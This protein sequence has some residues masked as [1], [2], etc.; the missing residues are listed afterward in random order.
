MLNYELT[1][2]IEQKLIWS[3]YRKMVAE[4]STLKT[5]IKPRENL[6]RSQTFSGPLKTSLY[7]NMILIRKIIVLPMCYKHR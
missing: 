7:T 3:P 1:P 2:Y 6:K 5:Y 4:I